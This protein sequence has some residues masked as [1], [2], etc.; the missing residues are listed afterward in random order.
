MGQKDNIL[1]G[2]VEF[3]DYE[4]PGLAAGKYTVSATLSL[5]DTDTGQYTQTVIQDF[6]VQGPQFTLDPSEVHATFPD[7]NA[8]GDFS[9]IL[10]SVIL[11][12]P[13]LPWERAITS[14]VTVPWLALL[15]FQPHEIE[16][17]A[18]THS[19]LRTV[20]VRKF[21]E[22][23]PGVV[24]P[25]IDQSGMNDKTLDGTMNSI[26][27][28][29]EV[30]QAVTPCLNELSV[31][32][33][34]RQVNIENQASDGEDDGWYSVILANRFPSPGTSEDNT[35][36]MHYVHLVS[37]EGLTDYLT[38]NPSW[39]AGAGKVELA[40]LASWTFVTVPKPG[41]TFG[42]LAE[43]LIP[44]ESSDPSTLLLTMPVNNDGSVAASRLL[45]GYT[46]LSFHTGPGPDTFCWYRG[47]FTAAPP[48][49]LPGEGTSY[50]N[51]SMAMIYDQANGIFD[52][53]YAAA[54]SMGRMTALA[55]PVFTEA[56]QRIRRKLLF[57][58]TRLLERSKMTHLAG[59]KDLK[60]LASP[61]L[62]R[63][64]FGHQVMTGMGRELTE[65]LN[66]PTASG[67]GTK[68]R[69]PVNFLYPGE[70][71]PASPAEEMKW[72]VN[73]PEIRNFL[74]GQAMDEMDPLAEWLGG[75][76]LLE[77]IPFNHLVPDQRML[78]VESVRFFYIDAGWIRL[79][80]DGAMSIGVHGTREMLAQEMIAEPLRKLSL[81]KA[82][83][84]RSRMFGKSD[85]LQPGTTLPASGMLLR[86]ALVSGWPGL[87]V[88]ATANGVEVNI[89]RME[90]MSP[91]ILLMLWSDIPDTVVISQPDQGLT[92]GVEDGFVIPRRS[93]DASSLGTQL[94]PPSFPA[95]GDFTQYMRTPS[96]NIGTQVLRLFP[97]T[98]TDSAL[99]PALAQALGLTTLTPSQFAIEMV[100]APQRITFE[101]TTQTT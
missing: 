52:N 58:G 18:A 73:K 92:F 67:S 17:D 85:N 26:R 93:L 70:Q 39:P 28:S 14:D 68:T 66:A 11:E 6:V 30:F 3:Y 101:V 45:T 53:S 77:G 29:T 81:E 32:A 16:V 57:T 63:K 51:P 20:S 49:P 46:A 12:N 25:A 78:P 97:Q 34:V 1:P 60:T 100:Q 7:N 90:L 24:K 23:E 75:L 80:M 72:F 2:N 86:S 50:V 27:I 79:L 91:N 19:T 8:H 36:M 95:T 54:W 76:A 42:E 15:V 35:G 40:S 87:A 96:G 22:A 62:T 99:I 41:Q 83:S 89:L 9:R 47:P 82:A 31:L 21:L 5:P 4:T 13:V 10:P 84:I 37:L 65:A 94:P 48:Q 55:D 56:L 74:A 69:T 64:T 61:G 38:A 43:N 33:H 71:V 59:I 98:S 44:S 88:T